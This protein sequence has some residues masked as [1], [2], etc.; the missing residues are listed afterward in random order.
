[1]FSTKRIVNAAALTILRENVAVFEQ[2]RVAAEVACDNIRASSEAARQAFS[3]AL[4][5]PTS[6]TCT[7]PTCF[8][9]CAMAEPWWRCRN[10][11]SSAGLLGLT[12]CA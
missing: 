3:D 4:K 1:M 2:Q 12:C 10:V 8:C 7:W 9:G 5:V 11:L 6:T